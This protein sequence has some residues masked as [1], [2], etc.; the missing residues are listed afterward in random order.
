[1]FQGWKIIKTNKGEM[2]TTTT[3]TTTTR[4]ERRKK[5]WEKRKKSGDNMSPDWSDNSSSKIYKERRKKNLGIGKNDASSNVFC[6]GRSCLATLWRFCIQVDPVLPSFLRSPS[7]SP[8]P[9]S[10][11]THPGSP[12]S[13][14]ISFSQVSRP[15]SSSFF[16]FFHYYSTFFARDRRGRFEI[17]RWLG[18]ILFLANPQRVL[19][20]M[21]TPKTRGWGRPLNEDNDRVMF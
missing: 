13:P 21:T 15:P 5:K 7:F 4:E 3:T 1:M 9:F 6:I 14:T 18:R 2:K 16:S 8:H 12:Y 11:K 10:S 20:T 17:L 19:I